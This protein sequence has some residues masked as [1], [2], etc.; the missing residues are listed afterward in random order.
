MTVVPA[1]WIQNPD[2]YQPRYEMAWEATLNRPMYQ[3]LPIELF[4]R[5]QQGEQGSQQAP[6]GNKYE[7][8]TAL[9]QHSEMLS[10]RGGGRLF[11]TLAAF[12]AIATPIA[13]DNFLQRHT[14]VLGLLFSAFPRIKAAWG[15]EAEAELAVVEDPEGGFPLLMV[16]IISDNPDAY[17]A[18][19]KFDEEW[20][21]DN[22]RDAEG[23]LNFSLRTANEF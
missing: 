17:E 3:P 9:S 11:P 7:A 22:I 20:W 12:Y 5:E 16:R 14:Q 18:L 19:E 2:A 8:G 21:L 10:G 6:L 1:Q 13:I 15:D 23:L 4:V